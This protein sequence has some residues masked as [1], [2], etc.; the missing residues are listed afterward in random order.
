MTLPPACSYSTQSQYPEAVLFEICA[1]ALE[2]VGLVTALS[3]VVVQM[4]GTGAYRCK[5]NE[6]SREDLP[7][8]FVCML[9]R[10]EQNLFLNGILYLL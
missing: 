5:G 3:N 4:G 10:C 7:F 8:A 9:E 1:Q 2:A 6:S